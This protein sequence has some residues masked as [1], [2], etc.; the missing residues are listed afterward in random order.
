MYVRYVI[1]NRK[2]TVKNLYMQSFCQLNFRY[3][4]SDSPIPER[5]KEE[6]D[7]FT[8][9]GLLYIAK[10]VVWFSQHLSSGVCVRLCKTWRLKQEISFNSS[11][12]NQK[13]CLKSDTLYRPICQYTIYLQHGGRFCPW[14]L[15][16]WQCR[17]FQLSVLYVF[18]PQPLI[19]LCMP[20]LT[21][22][23]LDVRECFLCGFLPFLSFF[24]DSGYFS[25][26]TSA[27]FFFPVCI[28]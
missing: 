3:I 24:S 15:V 13:M 22:V 27:W 10:H 17:H 23:A 4:S 26:Y 5:L 14:S 20:K 7:F 18:V 19:F 2:G 1:R 28:K 12:S 6:S 8:G 21:F 16:E 9:M 25:L 11:H